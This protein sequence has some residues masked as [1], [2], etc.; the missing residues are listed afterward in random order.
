[1]GTGIGIGVGVGLG[2]R[3]VPVLP[4]YLPT[5]ST[6]PNGVYGLYKLVAAY[7]GSAIR[8]V[9]ASDSAQ[10]DIGFVGSSLDLATALSFQ[11]ASSLT[12]TKIYDQSGNGYDLVQ[13]TAANQYALWLGAGGP[14]IT[15]FSPALNYAIPTTLTANR[16]NVSV[17]L[18]SRVPVESVGVGFWEF[19]DFA[20]NSDLGLRTFSGS[21]FNM[22]PVLDGASPTAPTANTN[23]NNVTRMGQINMVSSATAI[24]IYRDDQSVVFNP[25]TSR[26]MVLGGKLGSTSTVPNS[27]LDIVAFVVY[28]AALSAP[29]Y[30]SVNVALKTITGSAAPGGYGHIGQ[31]D[32]IT[33]GTSCPNNRTWEADVGDALAANQLIRNLGVAGSTAQ[34][35]AGMWNTQ[36]TRFSVSG[37]THNMLRLWLGRNDIVNNSSAATTIGYLL[38]IITAA[39]ANGTADRIV[40]VTALPGATG[41]FTAPQEAQRLLLN[42]WF[43]SDPLDNNGV[44][45][46]DA[47]DDIASDSVIGDIPTA[48]GQGM[49]L[50]MWSTDGVHPTELAHAQRVSQNYLSALQFMGIPVA[51]PVTTGAP[52]NLTAPVVTP[53]SAGVGTAMS[54]TPGT[55]SNASGSPFTV[56]PTLYRYQWKRDGAAISGATLS[57]Y[58]TAIGDAGHTL[59]CAVTTSTA[60]GSTSVTSNGIAVSNTLSISGTPVTTGNQGVA[61]GPWTAT[62]GGGTPPYTFSNTGTAYPTGISINSSTGVSSGTPTGSGTVTG[63]II[64][65][66]DSVGATASLASFNLSVAAASSGLLDQISATAIGAFSLRRLRNAY[67]GSAIK[68]RRSSDNATQNIGFDGAG[69]FDTTSLTTFIGSNSGF[70]DTWYDQSGS[71]NDFAQATTA[72]QPRIVNAGVVDVQNSLPSPDFLSSTGLTAGLTASP[73]NGIRSVSTVAAHGNAA[74]GDILTASATGGFLTRFNAAHT[75]YLGKVGTSYLTSTSAVTI[76]VL[77]ATFVSITPTAEAITISGTAAGTGSTASSF[78]GS[79]T[80]KIGLASGALIHISELLIFDGTVVSGTDQTTIHTNQAAYYSVT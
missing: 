62:A 24:T 56:I 1:M 55:W 28:P 63:I 17:F 41:I 38:Q 22:C 8:V 66:T 10:R 13:A 18:C 80:S 35:Q 34:A 50:T 70:I 27:K 3:N 15:A 4:T 37:A 77:T 57:T 75:V 19:G 53:G 47:V 59:T 7:A 21:Q 23:C 5:V 29:D 12:V 79:L 2:G 69:N 11:G 44:R 20:G 6:A 31:G 60:A 67:A 14:T 68:V 78:T 54:C 32:S 65:V 73:T 71:G 36:A 51:L 40:G 16:Q 33:F 39:R 43:R 64:T 49:N 72:S 61:Y 48:A 46:F 30:S 26:N 9:R 76:N 52:V 42:A 74:N 58:T 25:T 45:C